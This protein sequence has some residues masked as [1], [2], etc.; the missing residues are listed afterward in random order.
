MCFGFWAQT[1]VQEVV[2]KINPY[3]N[4]KIQKQV[5]ILQ[6]NGFDNFDYICDENK[7]ID[8]FMVK[9]YRNI[10]KGVLEVMV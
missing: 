7:S 6:M 8:S 3:F 10:K 9:S 4:Q 2:L 5:L 1:Y